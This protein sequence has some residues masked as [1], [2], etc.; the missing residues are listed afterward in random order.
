MKLYSSGAGTN[1]FGRVPP[2]FGS[3][4]TISRLGERFRDGQYS[5]VIFLFA[6]LLLALCPA[7]CKS[8]GTCPPPPGAQWS[9]RHCYTVSKNK[10]INLKLNV[11]R[12]VQEV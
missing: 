4:S 5:L 11:R 3:K 6:V 9:R 10:Q 2:L 8:G 12:A 7:I 1:S